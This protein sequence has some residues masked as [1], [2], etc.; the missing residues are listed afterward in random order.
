MQIAYVFN[1]PMNKVKKYEATKCLSPTVSAYETAE[2]TAA[3]VALP[4]L[5]TEYIMSLGV[6]ECLQN[7]FRIVLDKATT[8]KPDTPSSTLFHELE[9]ALPDDYKKLLNEALA[10]QCLEQMLGAQKII[11]RM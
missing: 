6:A 9:E 7:D 2:S 10:A 11:L 8:A 4:K 3:G 5:A 1:D